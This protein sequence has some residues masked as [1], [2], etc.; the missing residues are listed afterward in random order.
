MNVHSPAFPIARLHALAAA[1]RMPGAHTLLQH[2][3]R[4]SPERWVHRNVHYCDES[5]KSL[6]EARE[7]GAPLSTRE[8]RSSFF[9]YLAD[10]MAPAGFAA[11]I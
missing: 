8:G 3:I 5:V 4:R 9:R 7:Y 1:L 2:L 10:T 6:E 11:F